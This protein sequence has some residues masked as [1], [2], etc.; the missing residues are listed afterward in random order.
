MKT[1][2]YEKVQENNKIHTEVSYEEEAVVAFVQK[3]K[4]KAC[5]T[6][7][8]DYKSLYTPFDQSK[9]KEENQDHFPRY[10]V[11][12]YKKTVTMEESKSNQK[13][14]VPVYHYEYD[15]NYSPRLLTLM[16]DILNRNA[17]VIEEIMNPNFEK[18]YIPIRSQ[19]RDKEE[20]Y[21][22]LNLT[23]EEN[24]IDRKLQILEEIKELLEKIKAGDYEIPIRPYYQ[25]AQQLF[26]VKKEEVLKTIRNR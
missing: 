25:E 11:S 10:T 6:I 9:G 21:R 5:Y 12:N 13:L 22:N 16:N 14:L 26:T 19:L 15:I 4:E 24:M 23:I 7:H 20:Q 3:L 1:I 2:A 17:S 8:Y 18:E